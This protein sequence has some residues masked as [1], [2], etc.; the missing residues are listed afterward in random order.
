MKKN[1]K[2]KKNTAC[3][4]GP[5]LPKK[6]IKET[7]GN[8]SDEFSFKTIDKKLKKFFGKTKIIIGNRKYKLKKYRWIIVIILIVLLY[9]VIT[10]FSSKETVETP[11]GPVVITVPP[12]A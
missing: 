5:V 9:L 4:C 7:F 6:N 1:N 11:T 8:S 10:S 12:K 2:I 3:P